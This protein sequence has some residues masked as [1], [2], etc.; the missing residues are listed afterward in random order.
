[1]IYIYDIYIYMIYIYDMRYVYIYIVQRRPAP[2]P[3]AQWGGVFSLASYGSPPPPV[4]CIV[5]HCIAWY[6]IVCYCMYVCIVL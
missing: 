5:L 2:S 4:V 3:P 1:M 6:C